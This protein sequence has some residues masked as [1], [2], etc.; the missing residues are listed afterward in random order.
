MKKIGLVFAVLAFGPGSVWAAES[1]ELTVKGK[2]IPVACTPVFANGGAIDYGSI[3]SKK[4]S[5]TDFTVLD[6]KQIDFSINCGAPVKAAFGLVAGKPDT[7]AGVDAETNGFGT[8][9]VNLFDL[10]NPVLAT[11]IGTDAKGGKIGGM[12]INLKQGNVKGDGVDRDLLEAAKADK[13]TFDKKDDSKTLGSHG[14]YTVAETG[15]VV[16]VAFTALTSTLDVQ[17]FLNKT[18]ALDMSQAIELDGLVTFEV[19]YL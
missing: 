16:P 11:G 5:K 13:P 15:S 12:A 8:T 1:A 18:D 10:G 19:K 4:M 9:T 3:D 6:Q 14:L 7:L 2:I 17:A